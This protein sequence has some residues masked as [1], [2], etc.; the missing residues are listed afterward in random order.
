MELATCCLISSADVQVELAWASSLISEKTV[1]IIIILMQNNH[2]V[3]RAKK[4]RA[5]VLVTHLQYWQLNHETT[6]II[7][8]D[9]LCM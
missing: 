9:I 3:D 8:I 7:E 4:N 5:D 1:C 2:V 6:A